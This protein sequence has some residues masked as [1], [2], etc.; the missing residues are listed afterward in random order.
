MSNPRFTGVWIPAEV[1]SL[2][3]SVSA[4]VAYGI[5]AGLD[6]EDGCF[7]SNGYLS[8]A[9]SVSERQVRTIIWELEEAKLVVRG[10]TNGIRI[11]RT[12]EKEALCKALGAEENFLPRRKKT[13]AG[14]GRKLPPY[15]IDDNIGDSIKGMVQLP[16][17]SEEFKD[18]WNKYTNHRRQLQRPISKAQ[19]V[20]LFTQFT[21]WGEKKAVASI[22]NSILRG[23]VGVFPYTE[24]MRM[25][26]KKQ[27]TKDDH[28]KF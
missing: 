3:L 27:L 19:I 7:A 11:I 9:L 23:W 25:N 24:M 8:N 17:N 4:K 15:S 12:I 22:I 6:N 10:S 26:D 18:A 13:S 1:L 14:G 20:A 2:P 28:A 21:E 5:L 16:F